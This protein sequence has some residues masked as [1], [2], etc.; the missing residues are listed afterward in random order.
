[1][2]SCYV[3]G[4]K[5]EMQ[6]GKGDG[7]APTQEGTQSD[8]WTTQVRLPGCVERE[9]RAEK[10]ST[11]VSLNEII[12]RRITMQET[13]PAPPAA[14]AAMSL[15]AAAYT[16]LQTLDD[17]HQRI[18]LDNVAE[19]QRSLAEY[20]ISALKLVHDRGESSHLMP[21][22]AM[23]TSLH[24][25]AAAPAQNGNATTELLCEECQAVIPE[26]YVR[27]GQ[28]YCHDKDDGS[29]SC[30]TKAQM[31]I[32]KENREMQSRSLN[33]GAAAFNMGAA[34]PKRRVD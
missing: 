16:I 3:V 15:D 9:V 5:P 21:D 1:M 4:S 28:R 6:Q 7:M 26:P 2:F 25:K 8:I 14:E 29:T 19:H 11:G 33:R 12:V 34:L 30:G 32:V 13:P 27:I 20:I 24:T 18:L 31:R 10:E 23:P 17:D 22:A